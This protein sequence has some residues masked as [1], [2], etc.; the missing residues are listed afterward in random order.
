MAP[1]APNIAG[2][3]ASDAETKRKLLIAPIKDAAPMTKQT[4][5]RAIFRTK[6]IVILK[7]PA[8]SQVRWSEQT[9]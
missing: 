3:W 8:A 9:S 5:P 6:P 1:N 2:M 4:R 7:P